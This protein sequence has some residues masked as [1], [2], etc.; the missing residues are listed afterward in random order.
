LVPDAGHAGLHPRS[1]AGATI[2]TDKSTVEKLLAGKYG[3]KYRA[4]I[5]FGALVR[6]LRRQ[7]APAEVTIRITPN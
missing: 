7:P 5:R 2:E 3:W 1:T 4:Y 6:K